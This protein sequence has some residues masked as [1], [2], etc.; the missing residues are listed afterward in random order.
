MPDS[1]GRAYFRTDV[2]G[3]GWKSN[4][5]VRDE[6]R[7]ASPQGGVPVTKPAPC[8]VARQ[9]TDTDPDI[10]PGRLINFKDHLRQRSM[11]TPFGR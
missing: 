6:L 10:A 2:I 3:N 1:Q 7:A 11:T 5:M 8:P 9:M 4:L